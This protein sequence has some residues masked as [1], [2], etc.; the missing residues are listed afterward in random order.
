[1]KILNEAE[2]DHKNK[3]EESIKAFADKLEEKIEFLK[4]KASE[5]ESSAKESYDN[6]IELLKEKK[7]AFKK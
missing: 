6:R 2:I 1:M 5:V 4:G 3:Y 7:E